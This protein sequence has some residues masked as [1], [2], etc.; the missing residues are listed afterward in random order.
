MKEVCGSCHS[1][2]GL[3]QKDEDIRNLCHRYISS[4]IN[5]F[6]IVFPFCCQ[7]LYFLLPKVTDLVNTRWLFFS[8]FLRQ[9]SWCSPGWTWTWDLPTSAS[10]SAG[11]TGKCHHARLCLGFFSPTKMFT[12]SLSKTLLCYLP[13][14][15]ESLKEEVQLLRA[16][17]TSNWHMTCCCEA[18]LRT[19]QLLSEGPV[20]KAC[21]T[22]ETRT[23]IPRGSWVEVGIRSSINC[24]IHFE[25]Y[26]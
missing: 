10:Q 21:L 8:H 15:T 20:K 14:N 6:M 18:L 11:I 1:V 19:A 7:R 22:T 17:R 24:R 13:C 9:V 5:L 2:F 12:I 26:L 23:G 25:R 16:M 4:L 3:R